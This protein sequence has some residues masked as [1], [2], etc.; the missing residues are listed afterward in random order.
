MGAIDEQPDAALLARLVASEPESKTATP[1]ERKTA[2]PSHRPLAVPI[3]KYIARN[4]LDAFHKASG[5]EEFTKRGGE[6][7]FVCPNPDHD[8]KNPSA[9]LNPEKGSW[10]CRACL[11]GGGIAELYAAV[12]GLK[13]ASDFDRIERELA[14]LLGVKLSATP[15]TRKKPKLDRL[16]ESLPPYTLCRD[17]NGESYVTIAS[18]NHDETYRTFDTGFA[19]RLAGDFF[20]ETGETI[21]LTI[22]QDLLAV[23]DAM[24]QRGT[25]REISIRYARTESHLYIDLGRADWKILRLSVAGHDVIDY[26]DCPER[27]IRPK[28]MGELPLPV[29]ANGFTLK[30]LYQRFFANME[31][32]DFILMLGFY[33]AAAMKAK[34]YLLLILPGGAGLGKTTRA[35]LFKRVIDPSTPD[36]RNSPHDLRAAFAAIRNTHLIVWDNVSRLSGEMADVLSS[37]ATGGSI[38]DRQLYTNY[39]ETS[40]SAARPVIITSISDIARRADF[41]DRCIAPALLPFSDGGGTVERLSRT[42]LYEEF[43][44]ELPRILGFLYDAMCG[45]LREIGS[46][47]LPETTRMMDVATWMYACMKALGQHEEFFKAYQANRADTSARLLDETPL[48]ALILG[49]VSDDKGF[50]SWSGTA[51]QLLNQLND[52]VPPHVARNPKWPKS[53]SHLS[54]QLAQLESAFRSAG[55]VIEHIKEGHNK[56]RII[57]LRHL[58]ADADAPEQPAQ[59][60]QVI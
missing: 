2:K 32:G 12:H 23:L 58:D 48:F 10:M 24:A 42:N 4:A 37:L 47:K 19:R 8:D 25:S 43:D 44:R 52:E 29:P 1:K 3:L 27:F 18:D 33:F 57:R 39:D 60:R 59:L 5:Q 46:V 9:W 45:G 13:V 36:L 22:I 54:A 41:A 30:E 7:N 40:I 50:H 6:Y 35:R 16:I 26:R 53:S 28:G 51:T 17:S 20:A 14:E 49:M 56:T 55:V 11:A 15:S 31:W 34:E 21:S 38:S